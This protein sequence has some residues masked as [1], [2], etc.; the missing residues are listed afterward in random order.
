MNRE[1]TAW[2]IKLDGEIIDTVLYPKE[3]D[4]KEVKTDLVAN[5]GYCPDIKLEKAK[6]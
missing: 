4:K 1:N 2:N 6:W 3:A 5:H